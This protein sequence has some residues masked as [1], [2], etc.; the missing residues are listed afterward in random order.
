M[1]APPDDA[2]PPVIELMIDALVGI[3]PNAPLPTALHVMV[4]AGVR[5]IPVIDGPD[6]VGMLLESDLIERLG[7]A[8]VGWP[9]RRWCSSSTSA[10]A[11]RSPCR[12]VDADPTP[13]CG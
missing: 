9:A 3:V 4:G 10:G 12:A 13:H 7:Q 8:P 5:H 1:N 11:R 6:C 2:D